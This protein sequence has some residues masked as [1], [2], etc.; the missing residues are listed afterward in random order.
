LHVVNVWSQVQLSAQDLATSDGG[1]QASWSR[2]HRP[3]AQR[4]YAFL[5][6]FARP[7]PRRIAI[8]AA[9]VLVAPSVATGF[10]FDDY[11][12][13]DRLERPASDWAGSAP[14]DLF[15][16][17]DPAHNQHLM[18][19]AG[20]P[21]WTHAGTTIAFMRPVS[22]LTH[23]L[24]HWLWP[25]SP[26]GMHLQNLV[27]FALLLGLA[28][29]AYVELLDSRW[30]AGVAGAM[31]ALDSA[32]G[33]AVGWISNRNALIAG[34]FGIAALLLHH[35]SR[36][37]AAA[38]IALVAALCFGLSLFAA[39]LGLGSAGYLV[40]YALCFDRASLRA[41]SASM[42]P[43]LAIFAVWVV[44]RHAGHYGVF[45]LGSYVDPLREPLAFLG[46]LPGRAAVLMA[47]Q[48]S[49]LGADLYTL[50]PVASQRVLLICA[51]AVC[52]V[53]LWFVWPS[54]RAERSARF[55]ATG[56]VLSLVPLAAGA[57]SD[58]LLTLVGLGVMPL[59]AA[60]MQTPLH[61]ARAASAVRAWSATTR[62]RSAVVRSACAQLL[63]LV[64][65][66]V[67]PLL[68]PLL[69][70]SPSLI[71]Q[72][73]QTVE[74]SLPSTAALREQTV[75]VAA[76]PDSVLL[77]YL[78]EMRSFDGKPR[79]KR[80]YWLTASPTAAHFERRGPNVLRV[81]SV[82]GLLDPR[83]QERSAR[84][85]MRKGERIALSDMTVTVVELTTDG[86]PSVC[87]F[88]FEQPLDSA[89]YVWRTWRYGRLEPFRLPQ[90][91]LDGRLSS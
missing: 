71:A 64:H 3:K 28:A 31:F 69:A 16:W 80:L 7:W 85:P 4:L 13:L 43:Y 33:S 42:L 88:V 89:Q 51:F 86:R 20:L 9:L 30:A 24:D 17:T 58:R 57:P 36:Q 25:R 87:D 14:L 2:V 15:R 74:A 19:G 82:D 84:L 11:M 52:G 53:A 27:W 41:R 91:R 38:W 26:V 83:W 39:E 55:W 59:L 6:S 72:G 49:R 23:V 47:S 79:P 63:V 50:V 61:T 77:S 56:A 12:L 68:L 65:F 40:A 37:S 29:M 60:A 76:V 67:D 18:D 22:S 46:L 81:T 44:A 78:P 1:K 45:G 54:L 62:D 70:L 73:A 32:H 48:I 75:I 34:V 21:W 10:A 35:R 8:A 5:E 66:V 90:R